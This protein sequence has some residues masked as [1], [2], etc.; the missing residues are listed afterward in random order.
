MAEARED[1]SSALAPID[2]P[3]LLAIGAIGA[4]IFLQ[5]LGHGRLH[6]WDEGLYAN[7]ARHMIQRGD[8]LIPH[9]YTFPDPGLGYQPFLEKPPM[10]LWAQGVSM[11]L[12]GVDRFAA[13]LPVALLAVLLGGLVYRFGTE[14]FER[15]TGLVATLVVF[16]TPMIYGQTHGGRTA[17][18]DVP[19]LFLGTLFLYLS[20]RAL[21]DDR[22]SLLP[23]VGVVAG[24]ALLTKGF[25]AG[26][27]LI[28]IA[29][30]A[31]W[32]R[33]RFPIRET[34][35]MIGLTAATALPWALYAWS[36][37]GRV[38]LDQIFLDQVLGRAT[39]ELAA[40]GGAWFSFMGY[41]YFRFFPGHF[42]PWVYLLLPAVV[43]ALVVGRR[44]D[45]LAE[46]A[47]LLWWG[48]STF[49]VFVLTGNH[50]WYIM[51]VFVPAA[52]LVGKMVTSA[53]RRDP[54]G[55]AGVAA[56]A[57]LLIGG[58]GVTL[59]SLAIV[60]AL[61]LAASMKALRGLD[62]ASGRPDDLGTGLL[63]LAAT[64]LVAALLVGS[65]PVGPGGPEHTG[66]EELGQAA[67]EAVPEGE[68]IAL[69]WAT[70]HA[71]P[72]SFQAQRPLVVA[73]V[74]A[75]PAGGS[76][77]EQGPDLATNTSLGFALLE[78]GTLSVIDRDHTVL[79]AED[80]LVLVRFD[81]RA[82]ARR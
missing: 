35:T 34:A 21:T 58:T 22:P 17:S 10:V 32:Y 62:P 2:L 13:R 47:F 80:D 29:P 12:F 64:G 43:V 3:I 59:A 77:R 50:G 79:D 57:L 28:A 16:T 27:F 37:H 11:S 60:A 53:V 54:A 23:Y 73:D 15:S 39:G 45:E 55:L 24:L 33:R 78:N 69:E 52:L 9:L 36:R 6:Q 25:A 41:P 46:V 48:A 70:R 56:G 8:W 49:A 75:K 1:G 68:V 67:S 31:L 74:E 72:F 30:V 19:L 61:V 51:P 65:L 40:R 81:D 42:D 76:V 18:M 20:W 26:T 38:F 4:Y 63:P 82:R 66:Q 71:M 14:L 7:A 5:E 44:R